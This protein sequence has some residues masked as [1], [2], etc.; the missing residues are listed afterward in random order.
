MEKPKKRI[1]LIEG[2]LGFGVTALGLNDKTYRRIIEDQL[3]VALAEGKPFLGAAPTT[4]TAVC[5]LRYS[6]ADYE[7]TRERVDGVE[8]VLVEQ[9]DYPR[10]GLDGTQGLIKKLESLKS[11]AGFIILGDFYEIRTG[12]QTYIQHAIREEEKKEKKEDKG[13]EKKKDIDASNPK[14]CSYFIQERDYHNIYALRDLAFES[15]ISLVLSFDLTT[16][17]NFNSSHG[18]APRYCDNKIRV[19]KKGK[20]DL[21]NLEVD[22]SHYVPGGDYELVYKPYSYFQFP[23]GEVSKMKSL[24]LNENDVKILDAMWDKGPMKAKDIEKLTGLKHATLYQRLDYLQRSEKGEWIL[25]TDKKTYE[26]NKA[27]EKCW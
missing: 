20:G 19:V 10:I 18:P 25:R 13:E 22:G 16:K 5:I 1:N 9:V 14:Y 23:Q 7:Q 12:L 4:K 24:A 15:N 3:A 11:S 17:G 26:V 2:I 21:W 27:K 8:G 6:R